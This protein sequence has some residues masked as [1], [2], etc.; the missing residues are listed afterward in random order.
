MLTHI[1]VREKPKLSF[2]IPNA[3]FLLKPEYKFRIP[4]INFSACLW[5]NNWWKQKC[6]TVSISGMRS[7]R[8]D[9]TKKNLLEQD[10]E[11]TPFEFNVLSLSQLSYLEFWSHSPHF[12]LKSEGG[13]N[14]KCCIFLQIK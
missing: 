4:T 5:T 8:L 3:S 6:V 10:F 14:N 13:V 2:F 7:F 11:A 1:V 9:L 12:Y